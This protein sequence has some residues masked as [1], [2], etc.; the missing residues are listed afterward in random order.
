LPQTSALTGTTEV[1]YD[2]QVPKGGSTLILV[3]GL[4]NT[5]KTT[6]V[7]DLAHRYPELQMRP[8][9]GNKH[10]LEQ[11]SRQAYDEAYLLSPYVLADRS[12]IVSEWVYNPV[13]KTRPTAYSFRTWMT[14]IAGFV[15]QSQYVI[16]CYRPVEHIMKTFDERDQLSGVVE[17][18]QLLSHRYDQIMAM[19]DFLFE[20]DGQHNTA[21]MYYNY[22][23]DNPDLI[24]REVDGYLARIKEGR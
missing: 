21:V 24:Y 16:Y 22:E 17:N 20:L 13:L 3:E 4:D 12:R 2:W 9:I 23:V 15:Q 6:L 8:S 18:L 10:D 14:Y 1:D 19:I 11:I 7:T 5:G